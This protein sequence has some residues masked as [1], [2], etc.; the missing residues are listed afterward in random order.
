MQFF[1]LQKNLY[2]RVQNTLAREF[3]AIDS[4]SVRHAITTAYLKCG[5]DF[6]FKSGKNQVTASLLTHAVDF[7]WREY[8]GR[9]VELTSASNIKHTIKPGEAFGFKPINDGYTLALCAAD[10]PQKLYFKVPTLT[11]YTL[12]S[13][14]RS[15]T[16]REAK[17][18]DK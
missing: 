15:I 7:H 2:L 6:Y 16:T 17:F 3:P 5:G 9:P 11:G 4:Y 18:R 12:L 13:L 14:S 10:G 1:P 8:N